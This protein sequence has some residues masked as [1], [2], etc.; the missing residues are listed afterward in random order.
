MVFQVFFDVL[1]PVFCM[2]KPYISKAH[3]PIVT[4]HDEEKER[5]ITTLQNVSVVNV[6]GTSKL[7]NGDQLLNLYKTITMLCHTLDKYIVSKSEEDGKDYG[8]KLITEEWRCVAAILDRMFLIAYLI[9]ILISL[10][11]LFPK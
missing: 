2:S 3:P 10:V 11:I 6:N 4:L 5:L 8:I 1:T 9:V 7:P